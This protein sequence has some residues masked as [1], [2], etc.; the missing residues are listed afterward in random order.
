MFE[1]K[2]E[3]H[4]IFTNPDYERYEI[5]KLLEQEENFLEIYYPRSRVVVLIFSK[6]R[7][8]QIDLTLRSYQTFCELPHRYDIKV[9]Y[10]ATTDEHKQSYEKLK[11]TYGDYVDFIEEQN[12]R[13]DYLR[14]SNQYKY[15]LFSVDDN[16]FVNGFSVD[17]G[18]DIL[19]NNRDVIGF[20]YR[21][22]RNVTYNYPMNMKQRYP[23]STKLTSFFGEDVDSFYWLN[24]QG[25]FGYPIELSSSLYRTATINFIAE[26]IQFNNPNEL[27]AGLYSLL[28]SYAS[29]MSRL[30]CYEQSKAFCIP[31]NKVQ[32]V[33]PNRSG[34]NNE[35]D[36]ET[37]VKLFLEGKRIDL[38]P[39]YFYIP[40]AC[41]E[42][43][44][45]EIV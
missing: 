38:Y 4:P 23:N 45:L 8:M 7:A 30:A 27:E 39:F 16:V 28:A 36:S 11:E 10:R 9:L 44:E 29:T 43:K 42:E 2:F 12:F 1:T 35:Y 17:V 21:L 32:S 33:A 13:E 6:N 25:D 20:S 24:R 19:K 31:V 22:G 15:I 3:T 37:L 18:I 26:N 34:S 41:H 5:K 14:I 40:S